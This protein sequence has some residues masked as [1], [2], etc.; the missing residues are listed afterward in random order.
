M[1]GWQDMGLYWA[2][3]GDG[4]APTDPPTEK[5]VR[6]ATITHPAGTTQSLAVTVTDNAGG[7]QEVNRGELAW[8]V[9]HG[10]TVAMPEEGT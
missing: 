1:S 7:R 3:R 4:P 2:W 6:Y 5:R 8:L 10:C 9:G